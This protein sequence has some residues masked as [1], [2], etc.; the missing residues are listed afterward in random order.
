MQA[1]AEHMGTRVVYDQI[2]SIDTASRPFRL[3]GDS[4][5]DYLCDALIYAT[6]AQAKW[7]GIPSE[8]TFRGFG[9]SACATCDGFFFRGK[10][11]AIVGG[12]NTAVE[13]S[14]Y[15]ANLA[16]AVTLVRRYHCSSITKAIIDLQL[17]I[18]ASAQ[19]CGITYAGRC[20]ADL[21]K[22]CLALSGRG[23]VRPQSN[24]AGHP[25]QTGVAKN[26]TTR[27]TA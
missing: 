14:L 18:T 21:S 17:G 20:C 22:V 5:D 7:L 12:G 16:S 8:E 15:L 3:T 23:T 13:E 26:P 2:V 25:H 4:G 9:V 6:G 24:Q 10:R 11:V 1:Q 19:R 27:R